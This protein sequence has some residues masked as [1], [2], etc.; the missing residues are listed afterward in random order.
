MTFDETTPCASFAFECARDQEMSESIFVDGDLS[1]LGDDE[2]DPLLLS[3][4][5]A[6]ELAPASSTSAGGPATSNSTLATL[7]PAPAVF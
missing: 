1:A 7:E 3:T 4:T 5:S 2:D 6:P